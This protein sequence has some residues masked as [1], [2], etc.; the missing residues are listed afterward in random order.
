[1][2]IHV[3]W[4]D[5]VGDGHCPKCGEKTVLIVAPCEWAEDN[6]GQGGLDVQVHDEVTGHYCRKC[7]RLRSLSLN[8]EN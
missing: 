6:D 8:T 1:M 2:S 5:E 4:S 7:G 3:T